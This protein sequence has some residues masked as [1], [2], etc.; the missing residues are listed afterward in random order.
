MLSITTVDPGIS[1]AVTLRQS[2]AA[3]G[4]VIENKV[5][6]APGKP[7]KRHIGELIFLLN[8]GSKPTS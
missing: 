2:D 8:M 7:V 5:L 4:E 1:R 6:S 3:L